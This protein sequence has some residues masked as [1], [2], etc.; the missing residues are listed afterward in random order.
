MRK[1]ENLAMPPRS[2][3]AV[4]AAFGA[5]CAL[6]SACATPD[7]SRDINDPYEATNRKAFERS[8]RTDKK[9]LRPVAFAYGETVPEPVRQ[10]IENFSDNFSLPGYVVNDV[11]QVHLDDALHN[12]TRFLINTTFGILG[13]FDPATS[14]GL[15]AR[16]SDFGETLHVWGAEEGAYLVLP[17]VGPSTERDAV[18]KVV[19]LFTNPLSY[20]LPKPERY[21]GTVTGVASKI[22]DRYRFATTIDSILYESAD[23]YA[24]V[25]LLYLQNRRFE[26]GQVTESAEIDPFALDTEGF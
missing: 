26:L 5:V 2:R 6:L 14:A 22:G 23:G 19:D 3:L 9:F 7:V 11:L 17:I 20:T 13:I 1:N 24:Q 16:E 25:R 4:G 12:A 8:V 18:G 21:A 10:G 15:Y